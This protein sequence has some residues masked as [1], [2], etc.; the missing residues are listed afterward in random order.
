MRMAENET[1]RNRSFMWVKTQPRQGRGERKGGRG[2]GRK[3][4]GAGS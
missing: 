3:E 1:G 2:R 4:A